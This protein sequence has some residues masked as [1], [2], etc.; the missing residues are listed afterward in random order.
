[1]IMMTLSRKSFFVFSLFLLL[2]ACNIPSSTEERQRTMDEL[3]NKLSKCIAKSKKQRIAVLKI[4][5]LENSRVITP[6]LLEE[7]IITKL[8]TSDSVFSVIDRQN[9]KILLE[10]KGLEENA[11]LNPT[12][13]SQIGKVLGLDALVKSTAAVV[14]LDDIEFN[15]KI[16]DIE[17]GAILDGV[18][19]TIKHQASPLP[20]SETNTT[21]NKTHQ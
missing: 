7:K 4:E 14:N 5:G 17:S 18:Q 8:A 3:I 21:S 11:L 16:I 15:F 6:H 19:S 13:A 20:S 9:L 10:E 12:T 1:M 2:G